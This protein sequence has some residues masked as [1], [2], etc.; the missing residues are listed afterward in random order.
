MKDWYRPLRHVPWPFDEDDF[1][2]AVA[3]LDRSGAN[4]QFATQ[5]EK[6]LSDML[7]RQL[8]KPETMRNNFA[9][10]AEW[11]KQHDLAI[12]VNEF[13]VLKPR[14]KQEDRVRYLRDIVSTMESNGFGWTMWEYAHEFGF[15]NGSPGARV[16]EKDTLEAMGLEAR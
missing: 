11:A 9:A 13:G 14:V 10:V 15:A 16:Y 1:E 3:N 6:V 7:A 4:K 12:V 2:S 8:G 5:T